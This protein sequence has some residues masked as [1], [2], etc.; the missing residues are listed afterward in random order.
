MIYYIY[1][2]FNF[3]HSSGQKLERVTAIIIN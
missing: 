1:E 2:F 3:K